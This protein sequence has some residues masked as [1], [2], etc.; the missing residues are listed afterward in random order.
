VERRFTDEG[1]I[2]T[3]VLESVSNSD[4]EQGFD[5]KS[6]WLWDAKLKRIDLTGAEHQADRK[7]IEQDID[8]MRLLMKVFFIRNLEPQLKN[9]QRLED[10]SREGLTSYVLEGDSTLTQGGKETP[11]KVRLWFLKSRDGKSTEA[12][13]PYDLLGVRVTR[14]DGSPPD[15]LSFWNHEKTEQNVIMPG[16]IKIFRGSEKDPS[17]ELAIDRLSFNVKLEPAAFAPSR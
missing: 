3:R 12:P 7:K 9:V 11:V 10:E 4:R 15:T 5:G 16:K 14:A 17:T 13:V 8:Q 2:W 1:K 6:Y